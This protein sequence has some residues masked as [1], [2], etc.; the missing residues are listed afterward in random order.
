M[1]TT[2]ER[3]ILRR[4]HLH[5]IFRE[6]VKKHQYAD[7]QRLYEA[8]H[9]TN[10][11][12]LE[13]LHEHQ[14]PMTS[15]TDA[16]FMDI[17][18]VLTDIVMDKP[19]IKALFVE[20]YGKRYPQILRYIENVEKETLKGN[21][22]GYTTFASGMNVIGGV[23][24]FSFR[25]FLLYDSDVI[26][27]NEVIPREAIEMDLKEAHK[28]IANE[29]NL[30]DEKIFFEGDYTK[31]VFSSNSFSV[32]VERQKK[33]LA[34]HLNIEVSNLEKYFES[35]L[36]VD[37]RREDFSY[38]IEKGEGGV[39][40]MAAL[41]IVQSHKGCAQWVHQITSDP[42]KRPGSFGY[43]P[44]LDEIIRNYYKSRVMATYMTLAN[45]AAQKG[46]VF[47]F[48]KVHLNRGAKAVSPQDDYLSILY[49]YQLDVIYKLFMKSQE[50]YY[51]DFSWEQITHQGITA[52]Y[53]N[54]VRELNSIIRQ[55][56]I[57]AQV[58]QVKIDG[59][60]A[61]ISKS[62]NSSC[63]PQLVAENGRLLKRIEEQENEIAKLQNQLQSRDLYIESLLMPEASGEP[64]SID[65]NELQCRR[66]LFVGDADEAL[67]E[68]RRLFPNSVFMTTATTNISNIVVD[69]VVLLI[70]WTS[71]AMYYKVKAEQTLRDIP[72]INVNNKNIDRVLWDIYS[73]LVLSK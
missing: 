37:I 70:K 43:R 19:E 6:D 9:V 5:V 42:K 52:R 38:A 17:G 24:V 57:E 68:L 13:K 54:I 72:L 32:Y 66:Y 3:D 1:I 60:V 2:K 40:N 71:H 31:P 45:E 62:G 10:S 22:Q 15:M 47:L 48:D 61:Q 25:L 73:G 69:A 8:A 30:N 34:E 27:E 41:S 20:L 39:A 46:E 11:M 67:P 49:L 35:K 44:N 29:N 63:D 64:D 7:M 16:I 4:T 28:V 58:A 65:L 50:E 12:L 33:A 21:T 26:C 23:P 55:R 18:Y 53:E 56:E 36:N 59:L 14:S 51:R